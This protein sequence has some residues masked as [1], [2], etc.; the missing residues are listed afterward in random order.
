MTKR[1]HIPT[2]TSS[3]RQ[4]KLP[5]YSS[6]RSLMP[7]GQLLSVATFSTNFCRVC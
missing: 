3:T 5:T 7:F 6:G 1:R 2:L 4:N